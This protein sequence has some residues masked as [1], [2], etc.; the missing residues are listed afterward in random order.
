MFKD[1]DDDDIVC[2]GEL[3]NL[4]GCSFSSYI[5]GGVRSGICILSDR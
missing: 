4:S 2:F 3:P 5:L 1:N